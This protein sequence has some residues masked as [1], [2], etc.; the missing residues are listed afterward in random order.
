MTFTRFSHTKKMEFPILVNVR[1]KYLRPKYNNLEE[2]MDSSKNYYIGRGR[3]FY[4]N[5]ER[6]PKTNSLWCNPFKAGDG[7]SHDELI[8]KYKKHLRIL[9]QDPDN[10]AKFKKLYKKKRLG[11]WCVDNET[12]IHDI[13]P[14]NIK[15]HGE[16]ILLEMRKRFG[17]K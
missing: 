7:Y 16:I 1:V 15:C 4:I 9:L 14:N 6:F 5:G 17:K 12:S 8:K 2:W 10:L 13:D 11:C 3:I